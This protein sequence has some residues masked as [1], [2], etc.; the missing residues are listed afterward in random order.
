M[1][2]TVQKVKGKLYDGE[3]NT[4][5]FTVSADLI[6]SGILWLFQL[7]LLAWSKIFFKVNTIR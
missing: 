2:V 6:F 4:A 3:V 7:V 5:N 1:E